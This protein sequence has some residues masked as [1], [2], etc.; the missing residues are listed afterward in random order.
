MTSDDKMRETLSNNVPLNELDE[1]LEDDSLKV[2]EPI[3]GQS[4][5]CVSFVNPS[6]VIVQKDKWK[7]YKYHQHVINEYSNIFNT[8]TD[9]VL[10]KEELTPLDVVDLKERMNRVFNSNESEYSKWTDLVKDYEFNNGDKDDAE[11]DAKN[12]FQT[13]IA[14]IKIRGTYATEKEARV[15]AKVL[16]RTDNQFN[17]YVIPV[18]Y[19]IPS[20][21]DPNKL[22]LKDQEYANQ[23][24]NALVQGYSENQD[25]KN[26]FYK[27][28]VEQ[29]AKNARTEVARIKKE[30]KEALVVEE[31]TVENVDTDAIPEITATTEITNETLPATTTS[32]TLGNNMSMIDSDDI[33]LRNK[34]T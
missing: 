5:C 14:G 20:N 13:S 1:D 23:E 31:I 32:T 30:R 25:K 10:E 29:R 18:G 4:F 7:F 19:W 8:L 9:K 33:W 24:L 21:P 2:D 16:Q 26:D 27:E 34:K 3:H 6:E 11:F 22:S 15:R 12:N 28:Q 17:I